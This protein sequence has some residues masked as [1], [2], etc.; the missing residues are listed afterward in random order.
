MSEHEVEALDIDDPAILRALGH[1]VRMRVLMEIG[2]DRHLTATEVAHLTGLT[3]SAASHHLRHLEKY[4]LIERVETEGDQR[5]RPWRRTHSQLT[6]N[7]RPEDESGGRKDGAAAALAMTVRA[8][9]GVLAED[10]INEL[11][12]N[13]PEDQRAQLATSTLTLTTDQY[14]QLRAELMDLA[15]RWVQHSRALTDA[16]EKGS[17]EAGHTRRV[18]L[19]MGLAPLDVER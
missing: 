7:S 6:M 13:A 3:P 12:S 17:G 18:R 8:Q 11:G 15:D 2:R 4:G 16:A 1:P 19:V 5:T 9:L 14:T 10:L